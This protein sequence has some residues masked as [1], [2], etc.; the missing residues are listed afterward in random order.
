MADESIPG[1]SP[2]MLDRIGRILDANQINWATI[3]ALAVAY[4]GLVR[5]SLDADAL[6]TLKGAA[7]DLEGLAGLLAGQGFSVDTRM[8]EEGDPLGFVVRITDVNGHQVDLIGGILRLDP[9]F[10]TRSVRDEFDD[11]KLRF[12]SPE[13]LIALKVFAGGPQDI[14]DAESIL[15]IQ[16]AAIDKDLVLKLCKRFGPAEEALG[17]KLLGI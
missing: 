2:Q 1:S 5:A 10:F 4:H 7:L 9:G 15:D 13:D 12:S 8:G 11:M 3:G 6:I 17:R 14:I 16:Q